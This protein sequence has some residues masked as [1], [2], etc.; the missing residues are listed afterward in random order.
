MENRNRIIIIIFMLVS[1]GL[2]F[3]ANN[4][5]FILVAQT[6]NK[7]NIQQKHIKSKPIKKTK[8]P[9]K[10]SSLD[11]PKAV[12]A[13]TEEMIESKIENA[14][15]SYIK[16]LILI[17]KQDTIGAI[18]YFETSI[19]DLNKLS[20]YPDIENNENYTE[21]F[22]NVVA[23]YTAIIKNKD[24]IELII[25]PK[26]KIFNIGIDTNSLNI[27]PAPD[28]ANYTKPPSADSSDKYIFA[29]PHIADLQ[30]PLSENQAVDEQIELLTMGR[31]KRYAPL[32]I[33]RSSKWFPLM[34]TISEKEGMPDEILLLTFIESG[35]NPTAE[36]PKG[37]VGLWQ[38]M[39]PTGIDYNLNKKQSIW[40]DE[41]RD[42]VKATR[43]AMKYL[44]DLYLEFNDWYLALN[45][46]NWGWGNVRR[47]LKQSNLDKP[48]YWD[49]RNQKNI[50]MPKE[51]RSYV[52]LFL[53]ILEITSDPEK[54]GIDVNKLN[55]LPEFKYDYLELEQATN[56]SAIA[57][58]IGVGLTEIKELNPELLYDITPPDRKYY[59]LRIPVGAGK[60]F[61]A[62]FEKLT[63]AAKQPALEH[64]VG[65]NETIVSVAEKFDVS[66]DELIK[67]NSLNAKYITLEN[68]RTIK[69]PI[70]GKTYSQSNLIL[71]NNE[72]VSK[73]LMLVTNNNYYVAQKDES[74]YDIASEHKLNPADIRN[75]ND[76]PIDQDTIETGKVIVISGIEAEKNRIKKTENNNNALQPIIKNKINNKKDVVSPET[77]T[78]KVVSGDNLF[79]IAKKYGTTDNAIRELNS[80]KVKDDKIIVGDLLII[81]NNTKQ[82]ENNYEKTENKIKTKIHIVKSGDNLYN[83]AKKYDTSVDKIISLNKNLNP[84]KLSLGQKIRIK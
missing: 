67:L 21:L 1:V 63:D 31:L 66:I 58:C 4:N 36:S 14:R 51:A 52:P 29:I 55:Y 26:E 50:G 56:L 49:I 38:F 44:R 39:Y 40:V 48:T 22:N 45:A 54:Y 18:L 72:L 37:A 57:Q 60:N 10:Y 8:F 30:I 28:S 32:W 12:K 83:I 77:I 41:R 69:I 16:A 15:Q 80:N 53:A 62:N 65:R 75:W 59:R 70:G 11:N 2:C 24:D 43:A 19:S 47:A 46:Y 74:I 81:P 5:Y 68:N 23:D 34:K 17:D 42:P 20:S 71:A 64:R 25:S 33:E 76:I 84:D 82:I 9:D 35:L 27:M 7:K 3:T 78:Y 79:N 73:S 13:I 61:N 6:N